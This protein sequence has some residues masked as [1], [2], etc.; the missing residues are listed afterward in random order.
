M[1]H[2][3]FQAPPP[4]VSEA[5]AKAGQAAR[6]AARLAP[7]EQ[8]VTRHER[9]MTRALVFQPLVPREQLRP[10][11]V[12]V[13]VITVRLNCEP[14][15]RRTQ[16]FQ[17]HH[18]AL[19][20][21][22][23]MV[24]DPE[25][26][27]PRDAAPRNPTVQAS[28]TVLPLQQRRPTPRLATAD[29][30]LHRGA[31]S[32]RS[33]PPPPQAA[34]L[35]VRSPVAV[36]AQQCNPHLWAAG[37]RGSWGTEEVRV[38]IPGH[39]APP[40]RPGA[41]REAPV[42]RDAAARHDALLPRAENLA[43]ECGL[44]AL[45]IPRGKGGARPAAAPTPVHAAAAAAAAA[46]T[47]APQPRELLLSRHERATRGQAPVGAEGCS[48]QSGFLPPTRYATSR[49]AA[50]REV[51]VAKHEYPAQGGPST[52]VLQLVHSHALP[53]TATP[54]MMPFMP[55]TGY[56]GALKRT[57][58]PRAARPQVLVPRHEARGAQGRPTA[59]V[60]RAPQPREDFVLKPRGVAPP[61]AARGHLDEMAD[62]DVVDVD[63]VFNC[64]CSD[65]TI[66]DDDDAVL[67]SVVIDAHV[68][69]VAP[70]QTRT[71]A[72]PGA[73]DDEA[74]WIDLGVVPE[75]PAA[76]PTRRARPVAS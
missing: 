64:D 63:A 56:L 40:S 16:N 45:L 28:H 34:G 19:P 32:G 60:P 50:P 52:R 59:E 51:L 69:P 20:L 53:E 76:P 29:A 8:L 27:A 71:G 6:E 2:L 54:G 37:R 5:G 49:L 36:V 10:R 12:H 73:P 39:H 33:M 23:V 62:T 68:V 7:R 41:V 9:Y 22:P 67:I 17:H 21:A 46:V 25:R 18:T 4:P 43:K 14:Q 3:P 47:R 24:A 13:P 35:R 30:V 44:Q 57:P 61:H 66:E 58:Q 70:S 1:C 38:M 65:H 75:K 11:E 48:P 42:P 31:R 72:H 74:D 15:A 55:T 26:L